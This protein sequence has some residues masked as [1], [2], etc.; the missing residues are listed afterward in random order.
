MLKLK[1]DLVTLDFE[2]PEMDGFSFLRWVMKE[3]PVPVIMVSSYSDT[4]TVFTALE[5]GAADFVAKPSR[6]ASAE[7]LRIQ[8]DLLEKVKGIRDLRLEKIGV[9]RNM[10]QLGESGA[11]VPSSV[12]EADLQERDVEIVS[13][14]ASTG[15][16]SALQI[17]LTR[18]PQDFRAAIL[19][20]QH[21]P[22]G[23][24]EPFAERLNRL[25]KI[26]VKEAA[27]G[28]RVEKGTALICPGGCHMTLRGTNRSYRVALKTAMSGDKYTPSVDIMMA[29]VAENFGDKAMG[30]VLTGMGNDGKQGV[31]EIKGKGGYTIAESE[32][33]AVVFGMPQEAIKAGAVD[34]VLPLDEIPGA[35]TRIVMLEEDA[36]GKGHRHR[37]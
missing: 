23:F 12:P 32:A 21:M 5:L 3:R 29:S 22:K 20:S 13:I 19:I 25:A 35:I 10:S 24:T 30:V 15:G 31:V 27:D 1:P 7:L 37:K 33:T 6:K 28:D 17:V 9:Y 36:G 4:K 8:D 26:K 11:E 18:L 16:P 34:T 14:G 2:M